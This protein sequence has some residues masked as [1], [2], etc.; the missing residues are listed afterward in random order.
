MIAQVAF[1]LFVRRVCAPRLASL[2]DC[3]GEIYYQAYP[4]VR[5][6]QPHEFSIGPST[7]PLRPLS[8]LKI[9]KAPQLF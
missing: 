5:V 2:F 3:T 8:L 9:A 4:C 1:D 7:R 6:V